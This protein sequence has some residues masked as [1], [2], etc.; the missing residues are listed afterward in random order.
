MEGSSSMNVIRANRKSLM[1]PQPQPP[2][3]ARE[4]SGEHYV[5]PT[6]SVAVAKPTQSTVTT[7][8]NGGSHAALHTLARQLKGALPSPSTVN[9]RNSKGADNAREIEE[10]SSGITL[11]TE[12]LME[13]ASGGTNELFGS[14]YKGK[15]D[16][17]DYIKFD[18]W[19]KTQDLGDI[20]VQLKL[21]GA[22]YTKNVSYYQFTIKD[23]KWEKFHPVSLAAYYMYVAS[24]KAVNEFLSRY[25]PSAVQLLA[26]ALCD[27]I[28]ND[29]IEKNLITATG[30]VDPTARNDLIRKITCTAMKIAL[31]AKS[32]PV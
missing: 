9:V 22:T 14:F 3:E 12:L 19:F 30:L 24:G 32:P 2:S 7:Q 29:T 5:R 23:K 4:D 31:A 25:S 21:M 28:Q 20:K 26:D 16:D 6:A 27:V 10:I 1:Q 11:T 8:S 18:A 13:D 17:S 15:H